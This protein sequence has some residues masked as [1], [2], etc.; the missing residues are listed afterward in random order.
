M[1]FL[2]TLD[3]TVIDPKADV[4]RTVALGDDAVNVVEASPP[5]YDFKSWLVTNQTVDEYSKRNDANPIS[6][7]LHD[8]K[9]N[10][11]LLMLEFVVL[12]EYGSSGDKIIAH[13]LRIIRVV[14]DGTIFYKNPSYINVESIETTDGMITKRITPHS[15]S[16]PDEQIVNS[17][18]YE[19]IETFPTINKRVSLYTVRLPSDDLLND[20]KQTTIK[21]VKSLPSLR[22]LCV[23]AIP[24]NDLPHYNNINRTMQF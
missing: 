12:K 20:I 11:K 8:I 4:R 9:Y 14:K 18:L 3:K 6:S 24:T 5:Y 16:I 2:Q 21:S 15:Y 1:T 19:L 22:Q 10:D 23:Y 13:D 17:S 7:Y